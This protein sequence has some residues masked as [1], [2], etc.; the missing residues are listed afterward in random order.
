MMFFNFLI[1]SIVFFIQIWILEGMLLLSGYDCLG[2]IVRIV[3]LFI[4]GIFRFHC[5]FVRGFGFSLLGVISWKC[6]FVLWII[7][8]LFI[9]LVITSSHNNLDSISSANQF[10][11][12][13]SN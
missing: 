5:I 11:P 9:I 10:P 13:T 7:V 4:I 8:I 12:H 1:Q 2:V 3:V 6:V